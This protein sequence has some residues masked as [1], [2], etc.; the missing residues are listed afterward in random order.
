VKESET[1]L[2]APPSQTAKVI[3]LIAIAVVA[4]IVLVWWKYALPS[5][6]KYQPLIRLLEQNQLPKDEQGHVDLSRGFPGITPHDEMMVTRR[7]DGSF[8]ALFPTYYG[9]GTQIAGLMYTSRLLRPEDCRGRD[10][11]NRFT[12]RVI[13]VGS[14]RFLL[15]DQRLDDHWYRV[16]YHMR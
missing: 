14:Y 1:K 8:L 15:I 7:D 3:C 13:G 5:T 11:S 4:V 6:A 9:E 2:A 12:D 10:D 16:S